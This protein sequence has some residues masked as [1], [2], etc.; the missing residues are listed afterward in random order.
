MVHPCVTLLTDFGTGDG[1][2]GAMKGVLQ[3]RCPGVA[4]HDITHEIAPGD[5]RAGAWALATAAPWFPAGTIHVAVV[6]PGVGTQRA[7]LAIR[8][9]D[10]WFV[11]PDNGLLSLA[12]SEPEE[13]YELANPRYLQEPVSATF[14]GRDVFASVA[15]YLAA[16]TKARKL[17]PAV[18][19]MERMVVPSTFRTDDGVQGEIL[20]IDRFGNLITNIK[21]SDVSG[22]GASVRFAGH[23]VLGLSRTYGDAEGSAPIVLVG[24]SG[25]LEI[26]VRDGS[27]ARA[28][29]GEARVGAT[30]LVVQSSGR[31][32]E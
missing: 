23:T 21:A 20:H 7:G 2:V 9:C 26:A 1:F 4:I 5:I 13:L 6:D 27:A 25:Y 19:A 31:E 10:Q 29:G 17:G 14:H 30:V 11:G 15:G 22:P 18:A 3:R 8:H 32:T 16:G 24:S 12:A 28:L